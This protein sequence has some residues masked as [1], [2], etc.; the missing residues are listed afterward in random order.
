MMARR[1]FMA[2]EALRGEDAGKARL[3]Q[4]SDGAI[5]EAAQALAVG[6][7]LFERGEGSFR[8]ANRIEHRVLTSKGLEPLRAVG[9][10]VR[11]MPPIARAAANKVF[12]PG[13]GPV[14]IARVRGPIAAGASPTPAAALLVRAPRASLDRLEIG[15]QISNH[16][17]DGAFVVCLRIEAS[18]PHRHVARTVSLD[19]GAAIDKAGDAVFG[20]RIPD[21]V[22][23]QPQVGRRSRQ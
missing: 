15:D 3:F 21:A 5:V 13:Q 20:Q 7:S 18:A 6:R 8:R 19:L 9:A 12:A 4:Q 22:R 14:R 2:A 1:E 17:T 10:A 11:S 16:R 23:K